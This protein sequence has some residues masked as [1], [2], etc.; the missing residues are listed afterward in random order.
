[1]TRLLNF[2]L[3]IIILISIGC[4]NTPEAFSTF[5]P[6]LPSPTA[7]VKN[8]DTS[9]P[10]STNTPSPTVI[11][12]DP[13]NELENTTN[14]TIY[15]DEFNSDWELVET[16]DVETNVA[17]KTF[18][19]EGT[20]SIAITPKIGLSR[21]SIIVKEEASNV[22]PRD[23][24]IGFRFW[25]S[26]VN[27]YIKPSNLMVNIIGSNVH[28]YCIGSDDSTI[29]INNPRFPETPLNL[30]GYDQVMSPETWVEVVVLLDDLKNVQDFEYIVGFYIKYDEG[31]LQTFYIDDI[32]LIIEADKSIPH[33]P[34]ITP[35]YTPSYTP[36]PT[37]TSTSTQQITPNWS[38][39]PTKT[40]KPKKPEPTKK[41]PSK[42]TPTLAGP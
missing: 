1:M 12:I 11:S 7:V 22:Y 38:P 19:H 23:R 34:S 4:A 28:P 24:I 3:F 25:M 16:E 41:P 27:G 35:T 6:N 42:P 37:A 2:F 21:T 32:Q 10:Q 20:H 15:S 9:I 18:V 5:T 31:F 33:K 26:P 17:A 36:T 13:Y 14:F 40:R 29:T 30:L 8:P 39:T